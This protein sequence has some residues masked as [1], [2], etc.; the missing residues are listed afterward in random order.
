MRIE[1]KVPKSRPQVL[2]SGSCS[3]SEIVCKIADKKVQNFDQI[4][5]YGLKWTY[6]G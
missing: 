4:F 2:T 1:K 6:K 5:N 3:P